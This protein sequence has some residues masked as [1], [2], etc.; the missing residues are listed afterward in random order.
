MKSIL[1]LFPKAYSKDWPSILCWLCLFLCWFSLFFRIAR[2]WNEASYY[3]HG[4][5]VPFL[6]L[7]LCFRIRQ[8]STWKIPSIKLEY[9]FF[10]SF[11]LLFFLS[12]IIFEPDPFWRLPLWLETLALSGCS[13]IIIRSSLPFI[14]SKGLTLVACYLFTSLPWPA[15]LESSIVLS[16]SNLIGSIT[17]EFLLLLGYPAEVMGSLI[18]VDQNEISIN[19]ACSGIRSLQNLI[20]FSIFFSIY[21]RH[22]F[23][24]FGMSLLFAWG[25]TF[26]LNSMRA[27][28]LSLVSLKFG[29]EAYLDWHDWI[30][31]FFILGAFL[32]LL[33]VNWFLSGNCSSNHQEKHRQVSQWQLNIPSKFSKVFLGSV[34]TTHVVI[35]FWFYLYLEPPKNFNWYIDQSR[36]STPLSKGVE[37]VLQ[38]DYGHKQKVKIGN[39]QTAEVI[40]FGYHEASAAAS[41]CSRNH[42]PDHCM[43]SAGI[44]LAESYEPTLYKTPNYNLRF[45]HY[46]TERRS[47]THPMTHVFWCSATV[48]SRIASFEFENPSIHQKLLRFITGKLSFKRQVVLVSISGTHSAKEAKSDLFRVLEK[49]IKVK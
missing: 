23:F 25:L 18:L 14:S 6:A 49:V 9:L 13:I 12:R 32:S 8:K 40:F 46:T 29:N 15:Q 37:D 45:R 4:Y 42:P 10:I 20:S 38:F 7:I 1:L 34:L 2:W 16:L 36:N 33:F 22:N 24:Y 44:K 43:A 28:S 47:V 21:F 31:N 17:G 35:Y 27:L 30:G 41:L 26:L 19:N 39:D 3:T 11:L 48:D 5:S